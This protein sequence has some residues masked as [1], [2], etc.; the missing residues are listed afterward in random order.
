MRLFTLC[1][2]DEF[3]GLRRKAPGRI[4]LLLSSMVPVAGSMSP[5]LRFT[6]REAT[7]R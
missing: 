7:Q 6:R 4:L 1:A 5:V 2:H 3:D